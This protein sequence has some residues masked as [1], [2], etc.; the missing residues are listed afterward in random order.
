[1]KCLLIYPR[2]VFKSFWNYR[3]T[4]ELFGPSYPAAPLGL[5]T[6]AALLPE[7]GDLKLIDCNV[8][9]LTDDDIE[10]ADIVFTSGMIAQQ[11]E[12]LRL[13][14]KIKACSKVHGVGGPDFTSALIF[15]MMQIIW[16]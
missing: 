10:G 4:C 15:M 11:V 1:M 8:E 9:E 12:R 7:S 2:F 14:G 13:I 5:A 16:F 3:K 6:V